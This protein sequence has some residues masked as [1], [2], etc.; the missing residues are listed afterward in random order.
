MRRT[1][2]YYV[3][4]LYKLQENLKRTIVY[5]YFPLA[6]GLR[7]LT[8][9]W[10]ISHVQLLE[11]PL[12]VWRICRHIAVLLLIGI[13]SIISSVIIRF[14]SPMPVNTLRGNGT[15]MRT[16][17]ETAENTERRYSVPGRSQCSPISLF[18]LFQR[19]FISGW[20]KTSFPQITVIHFINKISWPF[21]HICFT[22]GLNKTLNTLYLSCNEGHLCKR[23]TTAGSPLRW[24]GLLLKPKNTEK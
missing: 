9:Y 16:R 13:Q 18:V 1:W 22:T 14:K 21:I 20:G 6:Y 5:N 3:A 23:N 11:V 2:T 7:I 12:R 8:F 17:E 4:W 24:R 19:R 15:E 10:L